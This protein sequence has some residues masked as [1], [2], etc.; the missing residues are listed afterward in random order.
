MHAGIDDSPISA[1]IPA[2]SCVARSL[3]LTTNQPNRKAIQM[4]QVSAGMRRIV[5]SVGGNPE[6][7]RDNKARCQNGAGLIINGVDGSMAIMFLPGVGSLPFAEP[8]AL[9]RGGP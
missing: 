3:P 1:T 2:G 6:K 7:L 9:V 4:E 5:P 8:N